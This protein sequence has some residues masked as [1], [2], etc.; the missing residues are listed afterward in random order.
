MS[1]AQLTPAD[2]L[3]YERSADAFTHRYEEFLELY[4]DQ[5]IG[6]HN[7]EVIAHHSSHQEVLQVAD[8]KHIDRPTLYTEF[9][10]SKPIIMI[11]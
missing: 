2:W 10:T 5:W 9:V 1:Q 3:S 7:G 11:L 4:P 8:A 6:L